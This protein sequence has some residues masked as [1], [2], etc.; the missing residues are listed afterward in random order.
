MLDASIIALMMKA[1]RISETSV[2]V[3]HI[4][5]RNNPEDSHLQISLLTKL[6][7]NGNPL[8][9][10]DFFIDFYFPFVNVLLIVL[11]NAIIRKCYKHNTPDHNVQCASF[12]VMFTRCFAVRGTSSCAADD[13]CVVTNAKNKEAPNNYK[14]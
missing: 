2:N 6:D 14:M 1:V 12:I 7:R 10:R 13:S 4:T 8:L 5:R 11:R 3:Y 9:S